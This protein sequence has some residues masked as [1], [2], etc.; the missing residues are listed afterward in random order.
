MRL[1]LCMCICVCIY[2]NTQTRVS[3]CVCVCELKCVQAQTLGHLSAAPIGWWVVAG[4]HSGQT[5]TIGFY[6]WARKQVGFIISLP[7]PGWNAAKVPALHYN[8]RTALKQDKR[9]TLWWLNSLSGCWEIEKGKKNVFFLSIVFGII[10]YTQGAQGPLWLYV[11]EV[12]IRL[13]LC[14]TIHL[15]LLLLCSFSQQPKKLY[16]ACLTSAMSNLIIVELDEK[17]RNA[18]CCSGRQK[19]LSAP[20]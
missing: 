6:G 18:R 20:T 13:D 15:H 11:E 10:Y 8:R 5:E 4:L 16:D 2:V 12:S 3:V 1:C 19:K 7:V 14:L 9:L 17:D